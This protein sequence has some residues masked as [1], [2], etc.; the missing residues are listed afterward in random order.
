MPYPILNSINTDNIRQR[1]VARLLAMLSGCLLC[2]IVSISHAGLLE[3]L[4]P[5]GETHTVTAVDRD[6]AFIIDGYIYDAR[7]FCYMVVG[8]KV[9]FLDGRHGID[10]RATV[11]NLNGHEQCD[12]LLRK[13]VGE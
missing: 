7:Q 4:I 6:V 3:R 8:D 10:Y 12:L 13:R 1:W 11:Y 9:V 5:Q 2:T